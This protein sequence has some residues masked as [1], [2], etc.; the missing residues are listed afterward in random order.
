MRGPISRAYVARR[1]MAGE[2]ASSRR[3][4]SRY[5]G[6]NCQALGSTNALAEVIEQA[7]R[8][9]RV[10]WNQASTASSRF[11]PGG[12]TTTRCVAPNVE[13]IQALMLSLVTSHECG[14]G[15]VERSQWYGA[16]TAARPAATA[17]S[18]SAG[19]DASTR[20]A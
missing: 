10:C 5:S 1:V 18:I 19:D 9:D 11:A 2:R 17:R 4:E 12:F 14:S 7:T 15:S 20:P 3:G 16:I 13:A 8:G 6:P